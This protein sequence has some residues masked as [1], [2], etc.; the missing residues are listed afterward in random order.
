MTG[1]RASLLE[2]LDSLCGHSW[3][4][5][6]GR[7][8][9]I[10]TKRVL[11]G[12]G[13]LERLPEVLEDLCGSGSVLVVADET[14]H[15]VAGQRVESLLSSAGRGVGQVVF[16]TAVEARAGAAR[17]VASQV[18]NDTVALIGVGAGTIN[19]LTKVAAHLTC[20][21]Y[22]SVATAPSQNGFASPIAAL[23]ENGIKV[24]QPA[25][26][27]VAVLGDGGILARAPIAMI[28]AGFADLLGR[29]TANADWLLAHWVKGEHYCSRPFEIVAKAEDACRSRAEALGRSEPQAVGMLMAALVLSSFSMVVGGSSAPASG[30][31]H[32]VSHYIDGKREWRQ[33]RSL[34][35]RLHGLQVGVTTL[36]M[37]QLYEQL[38]SLSD[39]DID[40]V[41]IARGYPSLEEE[42]VTIRRF[43]GSSAEAALEQFRSKY[44]PWDVKSAEIGL[45]VEKWE[46]IRASLRDIV[47]TPEGVEGALRSAGAFTSPEELGLSGERG[48]AESEMREAVL[49]SR[50]L[51]SRYTVLDLAADMGILS[52]FAA[53]V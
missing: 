44:Q 4:C 3:E 25:S 2:Y 33:G 11:V 51:R 26:P 24:T 5:N 9:V 8:H 14:T 45:L 53:E 19:D 21:K 22:I 27:P 50:Y 43:Y 29:R 18:R 15:A 35:Q 37:T 1:D 40:P 47:D 20:R 48:L 7:L 52:D 10:P 12:E 49:C 28:R 13:V 42:E 31:E 38:L 39:S 16:D 6:C 36:L 17:A 46:A 32:L 41:A 30:G 23:H 34:A